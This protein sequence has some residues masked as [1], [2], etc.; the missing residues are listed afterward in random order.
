MHNLFEQVGSVGGD[1][2]FGVDLVE[3]VHG[4]E[5]IQPVAKLL[6]LADLIIIELRAPILEFFELLYLP[7]H[8][9]LHL[10]RS[11]HSLVGLGCKRTLDFGS[12]L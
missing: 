6:N 2:Q 12:V 8:L 3:L 7:L 1:V 11:L 5:G 10:V 4:L 9:L